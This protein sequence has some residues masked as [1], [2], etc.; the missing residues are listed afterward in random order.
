[1]SELFIYCLQSLRKFINWT[2]KKFFD[3][4][5]RLLEKF[6]VAFSRPQLTPNPHRQ[7]HPHPRQTDI[8]TDNHSDN[9]IDSV[10]DT[11]TVASAA[12][13]RETKFSLL[14]VILSSCDGLDLKSFKQSKK[15]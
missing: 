11:D 2:S 8:N 5:G 12:F 13:I 4:Q 9:N 1:M 10:T 3:D 15:G 6:F 14:K 7:P